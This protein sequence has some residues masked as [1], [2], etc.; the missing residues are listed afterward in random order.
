MKNSIILILFILTLNLS[1]QS[2]SFEG[3]ITY[4]IQY[5]DSLGNELNAK[6]LGRDTEM[7]YYI[8]KGNYKSLNEKGELTQL[9][10][11]ST[12][13]YYFI[14]QGQVQVMDAS[15]KFPKSGSVEKF[16]DQQN[17]LNRKCKKLIIKDETSTTTYYY[18]ADLTVDKQKYQNHNFGNWNLYLDSTQGALSLKYETRYSTN[19][20]III[21]EAIE[22]EKIEMKIEDFDINTYIKK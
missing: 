12:N 3:R 11:S 15:F 20:M 21:M 7:H 18:T 17:I 8:S 22:V 19:G 1:A 4:K 14:N 10:N 13:K 6:T 2:N 5:L 16:E 9:Y